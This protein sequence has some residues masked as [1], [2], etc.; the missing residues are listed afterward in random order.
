[1]A[2]V[3]LQCP[4]IV[5]PCWPARSRRHDVASHGAWR[6]LS[7]AQQHNTLTGPCGSVPLWALARADLMAEPPE[8]RL[9]SRHRMVLT[10]KGPRRTGVGV[11]KLRAE[12]KAV[13]RSYFVN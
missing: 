4:R 11:I 8:A 7:S 6:G 12:R 3:G 2:Q 1:M 13:G 5:A 10:A 9:H